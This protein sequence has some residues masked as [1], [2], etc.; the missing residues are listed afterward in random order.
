MRSMKIN[1]PFNMGNIADAVT[2]A[3]AAVGCSLWILGII[4]L[5]PGKIKRTVKN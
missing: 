3:L 2:L 1:T 4:L 5:L